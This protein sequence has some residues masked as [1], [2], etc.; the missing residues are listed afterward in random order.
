ME[1]NAEAL[2]HC[3]NT[4]K[5]VNR[6]A[7]ATCLLGILKS[8]DTLPMQLE[9]HEQYALRWVMPEEIRANWNERNAS[10]DLDRGLYF[11]DTAVA[12]AIELG[13]DTMSAPAAPAR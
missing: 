10:H 1:K 11:L 5:N 6:V 12:R 13:F 2:T 8:A 7:H 9:A 4:A 3:R